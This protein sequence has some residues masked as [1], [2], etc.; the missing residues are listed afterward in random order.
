MS[1]AWCQCDLMRC[2]KAHLAGGGG[3]SV[4]GGGGVVVRVSVGE[5]VLSV[6]LRLL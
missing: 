3:C 5:G 1:R 6:C 4:G 2:R